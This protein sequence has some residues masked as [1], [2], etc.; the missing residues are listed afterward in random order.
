MGLLRTLLAALGY[1]RAQSFTHTD[2]AA[3]RSLVAWLENV[4][5]R[6]YPVAERGPLGD[7]EGADWPAA[8]EQ[9]V[10]DL[11][12]PLALAADN[13]Q[14]VL[15][16]VLSFAVSLEYTDS[17]EQ[18]AATG[19]ELQ[20]QHAADEH[21]AAAK[22]QQPFP[23]LHAP[24]VQAHLAALLQLLHVDT[25]QGGLTDHLRAAKECLCDAVLPSLTDAS[26]Q[27]T[28]AAG[29]VDGVP[30]GFDTGDARVDG[31]AR[32]LRLLY[33]K[34]LRG[35]QTAIDHMLVQ[36]QVRAAPC[37]DAHTRRCAG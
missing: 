2:E 32:V 22:G 21:R 14:A 36:A 1:P 25:S 15:E 24:E 19:A 31:L 26:V 6:H 13:R 28:V 17:A 27:H 4:K 23:D 33:I 34:D 8:F 18:Y 35:L 16:W 5:I 9:Y 12:C 10:A 30:L 7:L 11:E 3:F 20:Q 37:G 29:N